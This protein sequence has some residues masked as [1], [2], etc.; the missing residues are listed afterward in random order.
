MTVAE[1]STV[2]GKGL[3]GVG[4]TCDVGELLRTGLVIADGLAPLDTALCPGGREV[5]DVL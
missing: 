2:E 3:H 1:C 4:L 5:E